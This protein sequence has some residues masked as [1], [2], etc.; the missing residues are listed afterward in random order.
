MSDASRLLQI[1]TL[2]DYSGWANA[3]ILDAATSLTLDQLN[4]PGDGA[5][6]SVRETLVHAMSAQWGW[7][8]RWQS[9]RPTVPPTGRLDPA[10][11]PDVTAIRT[12]WDEIERATCAYVADVSGDDLDRV[13]RYVSASGETWAY[14]L[15]QQLIHQ[16]N[17]GTQHRSEVAALLTRYGRSPG[18][19]DLLVFIDTPGRQ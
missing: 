16:V 4:A 13:V 12:R 17:H 10:D 6:G 15:W 5:Y 2:Y 11:F 14:P 7:L 8:A 3:R 18:E 19:L 1:R 9:T